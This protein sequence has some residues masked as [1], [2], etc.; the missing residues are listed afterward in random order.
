MNPPNPATP[1]Y[2]NVSI[3]D[4]HE[5]LQTASRRSPN[6]LTTLATTMTTVY[7]DSN[8]TQPGNFSTSGYTAVRTT[9]CAH[10][11]S[12]HVYKTRMMGTSPPWSVYAAALA[13]T[14]V[15]YVTY[16]T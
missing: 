2:L 12:R 13:R 10:H 1:N 7:S 14:Y 5:A 11:T 4:V 8:T 16:A 3:K 6:L 15:T 9:S